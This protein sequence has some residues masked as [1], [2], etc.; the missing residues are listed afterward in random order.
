MDELHGC[1]MGVS[2]DVSD[3]VVISCDGV[4]PSASSIGAVDDVLT[5]DAGEL[6]LMY[7]SAGEA[8]RE[9]VESTRTKPGRPAAGFLFRVTE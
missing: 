7:S 1:P 5:Y 6:S 2:D 8:R 9:A 3:G 4:W